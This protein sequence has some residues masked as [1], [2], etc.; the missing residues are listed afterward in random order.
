MLPLDNASLPRSL[1]GLISLASRQWRRRIDLRLQ[2]FQLT[3][4]SWAPLVHLAR[5]RIPLRQKDLAAALSLDS[6][7]VVRVLDNLAAAGLVER[8]EDPDDRRAK[9]IVI[10]AAGRQ[11]A[12]RVIKASEDL[13]REVLA[14]LAPA[15]TAAT[16]RVLHHI[17]EQLLRLAGHGDGNDS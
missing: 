2:E 15:D 16:R 13:E 10:T 8:R 5:T 1:A 9:V 4:A 14:G 11:L 6:S 12:A 7:S 3:D 17:C